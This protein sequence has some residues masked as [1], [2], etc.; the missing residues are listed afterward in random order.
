[1]L[2]V[3]ALCALL[4]GIAVAGSVHGTGFWYGTS[5]P[6]QIYIDSAKVIVQVESG[7]SPDQTLQSVGRIVQIIGGDGLVDGFVA[8]SLST[9]VG[10]DQFMDSLDQVPG[11]LLVEPYYLTADSFPCPVGEGFCVAFDPG[12]PYGTIDSLCTEY[13]LEIARERIGRAKSFTIRNTDSSGYHIVELA[14]I[15]HDLPNV[16]YSHPDFGVAIEASSYRLYDYFNALQPHT[17]RVIGAFN[18][19]SVWDFSGLQDTIVV[20]IIDEGTEAHEDLPASRILPGYDFAHD[21]SDPSPGYSCGHGMAT[22]SIVAADHTT[23]SAYGTQSSSGI[24]SMDPRVV[25][26]PIKIFTDACDDANVTVSKLADAFDFAWTQGAEVISNSWNFINPAQSDFPDLNAAIERAT[27][28]GRGGLGCPVFFSSGNTSL[29]YPDPSIVRYPARLSYVFAVGAVDLAD[30]RWG[31]SCYGQQLAL[32]A[33]SDDGYT[34][35]VWTL[36][37]MGQRGYNPTYFSDCPPGSNDMN[38]DCHFGGTS[39]ACPLVSGS[40]ALLMS[41]NPALNF[42]AYYYILRHSA[43]TDLDTGSFT[44]PNNEYGWGRVDAFRAILSLSHG[45]VNNSGGVPDIADLVYLVA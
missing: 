17:K 32:V 34:V 1:M 23:D 25:I 9:G 16:E 7:F 27:V 43:V 20:A 41:K 35:P 4:L 42:E 21:D 19:A 30:N 44:P 29:R 14:N 37:Q 39:A 5:G 24:I 2:R 11:V 31:Y 10:Y 8:C 26:L 13:K 36:D 6:E 33:P 45:D 22:A 18:S 12:V 3:S 15:F 28:F 38:Y 40:A